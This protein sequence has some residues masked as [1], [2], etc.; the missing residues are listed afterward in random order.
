ME[1]MRQGRDMEDYVARRFSE[2]TG[3]KVRRSH[4]LYRSK[5]HPFQIAD[6]DR[7]IVGEDAG[8]GM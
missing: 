7:M 8:T 6:V 1:A 4:Q 2:K 3:L 5:E